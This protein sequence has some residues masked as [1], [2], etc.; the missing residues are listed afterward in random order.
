M[1]RLNES[2]LLEFCALQH[3]VFD[4]GEWLGF[5]VVTQDELAATALFL[6][7]VDWFGHKHELRQIGE[8]LLENRSPSL[9]D[10]VRQTAFDCS[11]F[12][13]MLRRKLEVRNVESTT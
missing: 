13:N 9:S 3:E 4:A 7:S 11:R 12:S 5:S 10:L 6:A 2:Q 1:T 8:R